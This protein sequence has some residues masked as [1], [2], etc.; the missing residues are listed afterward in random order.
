MASTTDDQDFD[1]AS[2]I[3]SPLALITTAMGAADTAKKTFGGLI[4][5]VNSLQRS[6][7]AFE[8]ILE[9]V[10]TL[11]A[12]IEVP[13]K[14]LGPEMEKLANRM[15]AFGEVFERIP[16]DQLPDV[17]ENL[18]GQLTSVMSGLAELPKKL[19]PFGDLLGG[20]S[21]FMGL[22]KSAPKVSVLPPP[23]PPPPQPAPLV[24][25]S[26]PERRVVKDAVAKR[27]VAKKAVSRKAVAAKKAVSQKPVARKPVANKKAAR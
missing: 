5:A 9:R 25:A 20:A 8:S 6:A 10:D 15:A 7:A 3:Q 27:A 19:G 17:I 4:E 12:A 23:P 21:A 22:T 1:F 11:V 24:S 14:V 2:F 18:V 16:V 13:A 26:P